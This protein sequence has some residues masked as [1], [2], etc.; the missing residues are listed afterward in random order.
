[1][2]E[3][4]CTDSC[5]RILSVPRSEQL[6][7]ELRG[8]D[9]VQGQLFVHVSEAKS[10]LLS[11]LSF[12]Y[13]LSQRKQRRETKQNKTR[14]KARRPLGAFWHCFLNKFPNFISSKL[15]KN[16]P[17]RSFSPGGGYWLRAGIIGWADV[18][19]SCV[20]ILPITR[21]RKYWMDYKYILLTERAVRA[22]SYEPSFFPSCYGPSAKRAG[23]N[24]RGKTRIHNLRT[25]SYG[26][27]DQGSEVNKIFI[28]WR[29]IL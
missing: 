22:V 19:G 28:I 26:V 7:C 11:S 20:T 23:Y 15:E 27:M 29:W 13:F 12:K 16:A 25:V 17:F 1:M 14:S 21:E 6:S 4:I 3:E 10:S 2:G 8:T 9:N 18:I 24:T 5:P